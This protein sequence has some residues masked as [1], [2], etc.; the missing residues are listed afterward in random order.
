[1]K[2]ETT[3]GKKGLEDGVYEV[4]IGKK[5]KQ[6]L[7][8]SDGEAWMPVSIMHPIIWMTAGS[9]LKMVDGKVF[10]RAKDFAEAAPKYAAAVQTFVD[11]HGITL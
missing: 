11:R 7:L 5:R 2:N 9:P 4:P 8:V 10:M 6:M 1:M 3:V